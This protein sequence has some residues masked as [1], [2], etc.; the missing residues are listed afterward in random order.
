M[1][2]CFQQIGNDPRSDGLVDLLVHLRLW[3][4]L[5]LS[6][7]DTTAQPGA[8]AIRAAVKD[9]QNTEIARVGEVWSDEVRATPALWE[10]QQSRQPLDSPRVCI[11]APVSVQE[12][13]TQRKS[14]CSC[15]STNCSGL[16]KTACT[17]SFCI[18]KQLHCLG[19]SEQ[20]S[21]WHSEEGGK[22]CNLSLPPIQLFK[23]CHF[24]KL[25]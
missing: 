1:A 4:Q 13:V 16:R 22:N 3:K 20:C 6:S 19:G 14:C 5:K 24:G 2:Y 23:W 9:E 10:C 11:A 25:A 12:R 8:T 17:Q 15:L 18:F 21:H 7:Y